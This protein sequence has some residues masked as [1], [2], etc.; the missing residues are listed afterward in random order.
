MDEIVI[1]GLEL[2]VHRK[3]GEHDDHGTDDES[4]FHVLKEETKPAGPKRRGRNTTTGDNNESCIPKKRAR[5]ATFLHQTCHVINFFAAP[6]YDR[7]TQEEP[8]GK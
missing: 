5:K 1:D 6:T 4:R 2:H 8:R 3:G 7:S